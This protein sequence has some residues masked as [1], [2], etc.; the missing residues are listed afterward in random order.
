M[1]YRGK[2]ATTVLDIESFSKSSSYCR[3]VISIFSFQDYDFAQKNTRRQ[4]FAINIALENT[5]Y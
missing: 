3:Q 5:K 2:L 4:V 1:R